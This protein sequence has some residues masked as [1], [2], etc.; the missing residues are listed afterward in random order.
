MSYEL[1]KDS[2]EKYAK[3]KNG[4]SATIYT[5][6]R[7]RSKL[8]GFEIP[9]FALYD[10]RVWLKETDFDILYDSY[11]SSDGQWIQNRPSERYQIHDGRQPKSYCRVENYR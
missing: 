3:T 2:N 6:M 4:V 5:S 8:K 7:R 10:F 11:L 1:K 9:P